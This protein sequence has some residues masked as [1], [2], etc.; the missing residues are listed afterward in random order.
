MKFT[1]EKFSE[2]IKLNFQSYQLKTVI[3]EKIEKT[4]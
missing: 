1:K 4:L 3:A 2:I